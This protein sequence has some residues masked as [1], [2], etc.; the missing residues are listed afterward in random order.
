ME[1]R[2]ATSLLVDTSAPL[3]LQTGMG[4]PATLVDVLEGM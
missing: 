1:T 4:I 3:Y 2:H